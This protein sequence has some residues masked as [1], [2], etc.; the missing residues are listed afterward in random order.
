MAEGGRCS[1]GLV[2]GGLENH[3][4]EEER[5]LSE[6]FK[7][8]QTSEVFWLPLSAD[9]GVQGSRHGVGSRWCQGLNLGDQVRDEGSSHQGGSRRCGENCQARF[10]KRSQG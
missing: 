7:Q 1:E 2:V 3:Y 9:Q 8:T 5:T 4:F 6:A 10:V